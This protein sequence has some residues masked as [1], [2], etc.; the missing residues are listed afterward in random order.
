MCSD[1]AFKRRGHIQRKSSLRSRKQTPTTGTKTQM[2]KSSFSST[3]ILLHTMERVRMTLPS[4]VVQ[5][6]PLSSAQAAPQSVERKQPTQKNTEGAMGNKDEAEECL[7]NKA[8]QF[9]LT[10]TCSATKKNNNRRG[11]TYA[12]QT[13]KSLPLDSNQQTTKAI[14][15][16]VRRQTYTDY[17]TTAAAMHQTCSSSHQTPSAA[18]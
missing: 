4:S 18:T 5:C 12:K 3:D 13:Q 9:K 2:A 7:A 14:M 16:D 6:L 15:H 8:C 10:T 17:R 11:G 1:S